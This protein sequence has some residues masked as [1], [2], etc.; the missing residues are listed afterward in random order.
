MGFVE[1]LGTIKGLGALGLQKGSFFFCF[2]VGLGVFIVCRIEG[3]GVKDYGRYCVLVGNFA[4]Y[5]GG[6]K[7]LAVALG[8]SEWFYMR[9]GSAQGSLR[10][11][12]GWV[13]LEEQGIKC[14]RLGRGLTGF[15]F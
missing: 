15:H 3:V 5:V 1:V 2:D 8:F 6:L 14:Y 7:A 12:K 9:I 13:I 11:G 10:G 4:N